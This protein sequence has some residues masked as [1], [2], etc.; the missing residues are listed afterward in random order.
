MPSETLECPECGNE[1][2]VFKGEDCPCCGYL[3]WDGYDKE[4]VEEM[5]GGV[6]GIF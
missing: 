3:V 1:V 6:A 2:S 4:A 5:D